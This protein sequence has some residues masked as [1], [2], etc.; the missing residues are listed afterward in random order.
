MGP[1]V[2]RFFRARIDPAWAGIVL[3]FE[4]AQLKIEAIRGIV[5]GHGRS[6]GKKTIRLHSHAQDFIIVELAG[7]IARR[8]VITD[9]GNRDI[10]TGSVVEKS[11]KSSEHERR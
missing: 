9:D 6:L 2:Q 7:R 5:L 8:Q 4:S 3:F 1:Q 10:A 11:R